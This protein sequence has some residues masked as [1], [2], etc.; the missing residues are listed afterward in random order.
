MGH[1]NFFFVSSFN[2]ITN[3]Y[4]CSTKHL[5]SVLIKEILDDIQ[6]DDYKHC[7]HNA[8]ICA[9]GL[10][11][12]AV[13]LEQPSRHLQSFILS[14]LNLPGPA[15]KPGK[16]EDIS[17]N[18]SPNPSPQLWSLQRLAGACAFQSHHL[19]LQDRP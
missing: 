7:L 9:Q 13:Y 19:V 16:N 3:T 14:P 4:I 17:S 11:S 18:S 6:K 10:N 12:I 15:G 1:S 8:L 5:G 2:P